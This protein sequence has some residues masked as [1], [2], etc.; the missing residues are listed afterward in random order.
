MGQSKIL[1]MTMINLWQ[2]FRRTLLH[3]GTES[4]TLK[5]RLERLQRADYEL[6][7]TPGSSSEQSASNYAFSVNE[8]SIRTARRIGFIQHLPVDLFASGKNTEKE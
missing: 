3:A 7:Y 5:N 6:N 8:E 2:L 4:E 1:M